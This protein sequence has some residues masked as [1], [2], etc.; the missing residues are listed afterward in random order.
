VAELFVHLTQAQLARNMDKPAKDLDELRAVPG[1][2][3]SKELAD[4]EAAFRGMAT[5]L[6]IDGTPQAAFERVRTPP[7]EEMEALTLLRLVPVMRDLLRGLFGADDPAPGASISAPEAE[8]AAS[9]AGPSGR[10]RG[11]GAGRRRPDRTRGGSFPAAPTSSG[12]SPAPR[13]AL[14]WMWIVGGLAAVGALVVAS[15]R[16]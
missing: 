12:S 5:G 14:P 16:W 15:R 8:L 4:F 7:K 6:M 1:V 10:R 11:R 9:R 2:A 3:G 13:G